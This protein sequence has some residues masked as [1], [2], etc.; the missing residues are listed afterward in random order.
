MAAVAELVVEVPM[1]VLEET[2]V[3]ETMVAQA[4]TQDQITPPRAQNQMAQV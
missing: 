2:V 4:G 3:Q 1:V